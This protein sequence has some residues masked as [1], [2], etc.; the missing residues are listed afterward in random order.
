M[1]RVRGGAPFESGLVSTGF[2]LGLTVGRI[3]LG[4]V[5]ARVFPTEK[6][7]VTF[8]LVACIILQL[9]FWV[10]PSFTVSA[11]MVGLL[12]FFIAP[13]FP[14]AVVVSSGKHSC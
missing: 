9:L 5:T 14:A 10:I 4:F 3:C 6:H 11:I 12:G 1:L 8:Y 13:M 2:W 7:A